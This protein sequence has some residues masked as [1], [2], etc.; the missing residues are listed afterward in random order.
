MPDENEDDLV[1]VLWQLLRTHQH[2]TA[3]REPANLVDGL[4]AV[5]HAIER[6]AVSIISIGLAAPP[7]PAPSA[8]DG[9]PVTTSEISNDP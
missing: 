3:R 4:F 1:Q 7:A 9:A 5:A 8:T 2:Y 6:V